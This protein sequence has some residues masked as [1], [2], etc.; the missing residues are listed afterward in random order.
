MS[1][2]EYKATNGALDHALKNLFEHNDRFK[3]NSEKLINNYLEKLKTIIFVELGETFHQLILEDLWTELEG[4]INDLF[5]SS[6]DKADINR[7][8]EKFEL[9]LRKIDK[10]IVLNPETDTQ[11]WMYY[12]ILR[13]AL[14]AFMGC[15][16]TLLIA[17]VLPFSSNARDYRGSFFNSHQLNTLKNKLSKLNKEILKEAHQ[18]DAYNLKVE[19]HRP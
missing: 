5:H 18:I 12:A 6:I 16:V 1:K 3:V 8:T 10:R 19:N 4:H 9:T 13:P 14:M 15:I 2:Y 7:F 11:T 17:P